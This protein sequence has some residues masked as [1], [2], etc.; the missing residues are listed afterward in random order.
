M[1]GAPDPGRERLDASRGAALLV[2]ALVTAGITDV[3]IAPGSRSTPLV[4][5]C[6]AHPALRLAVVHDERAGAFLALGLGRARGRAAALVTTSGTAVANAMPAVVESDVDR[7]PLLVISADRPPESQ[8]TDAN[9][10]IEQR[11]FFGA[12]VRAAVD[13]PPPED[14][15]DPEAVRA[16]LVDAVRRA[17]D[18]PRGPAHVN[19]MFRKPL[20]PPAA[21]LRAGVLGGTANPSPSAS[22][23]KAPAA[24]AT[25]GR[26]ASAALSRASSAASAVEVT[27][28]AEALRGARRPLVVAGAAADDDDR[29]ALARLVDVLGARGV[30]CAA[31]VLSG[32]RGRGLAGVLAHAGLLAKVGGLDGLAS[33]PVGAIVEEVPFDVVL[34][35]GGAV[36]TPEIAALAA[37][38]PSLWRVDDRA[39]RRL[40][41]GDARL[42][43]LS[44]AGVAAALVELWPPGASRDVLAARDRT[45]SAVV[46]DVVTDPVTGRGDG[47]VIDEV[48]LARQ[49]A[50]EAAR[51]GASLFLGNSMPVRDVDLFAGAD[52]P[53]RVVANRGASGIDGVVSTAA[54]FA[55]G[56]GPTLL[57][58]GDVSFLHDA[59]S[60]SALARLEP[61][62]GRRGPP[63]RIVVV[64]NRGG[65]IFD[66]LPIADHPALMPF[67]TTPHDVDLAALAR[68]YGVATSVA[69]DRAGLERALR[70]P[71]T[72]LDVVVVPVWAAGPGSENVAHHRALL[73]RVAQAL[74]DT[75][76]GAP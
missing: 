74:R 62:P 35:L 68:A 69:R 3:V 41:Q 17:H 66:F 8:G 22:E 27:A 54:G 38:A 46:T 26:A 75:A 36:V 53:A 5:A 1:S 18:A 28:L 15:D 30:P 21:V 29:L 58:V 20:E 12:R 47:F 13:V 31:C 14:I 55:L 25:Q 32:L 34:W 6:A 63:L 33:A 56:A 61:S 71:L 73:S 16:A 9:Q 59:G 76:G 7:V 70:A 60:L 39:R 11:G 64:D 67:F 37:R 23:P 40:E 48:T 10:T 19:A 43:T 65:G 44:P 49:V 51:A 42:V 24:S 4:A 72:G 52:L 57:L 2:D 45:A 50:R